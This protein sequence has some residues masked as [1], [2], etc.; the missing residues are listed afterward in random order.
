MGDGAEGARVLRRPKA[1]QCLGFWGGMLWGHTTRLDVV[2]TLLG[3]VGMNP[4][5]DLTSENNI[6]LGLLGI[7]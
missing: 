3:C 4:R 5:K 1:M 6:R 7:E 2:L